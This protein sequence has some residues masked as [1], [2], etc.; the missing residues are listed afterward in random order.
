MYLHATGN[1]AHWINGTG[2]S[3]LFKYVAS[4]GDRLQVKVD[5]LT[6]TVEWVLVYPVTS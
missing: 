6:N 5:L 2:G 1:Y 3:E 4:T